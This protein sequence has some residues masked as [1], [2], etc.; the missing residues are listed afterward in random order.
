MK[1]PFNLKSLAFRHLFLTLLIV[2]FGL[3]MAYGIVR[4]RGDLIRLS[5]PAFITSWSHDGLE[6]VLIAKALLSGEGYIVDDFPLPP[7]KHIRYAGQE[8]LFKAPLYEFF[9]AG[10]FAISGFSFKLFFPLQA[11][12]GGLTSA[13]LGLIAWETFRRPATAL[14]AGLTAAA[15]PVLVNSASEPYNENLFLLL[16]VAAIWAFLVWF[17]TRTIKWALLCGV[18]VGLCTLTRESGIPLLVAM[19]AIGILSRPRGFRSWLACGTIALTAFAVIAP[20]TIRNYI[21][22]QA[23][24]PVAAIVG[25]D[26]ATGNNECVAPES[27]LTPYW[28]EGPCIPLNRRIANARAVTPLANLPAGILFDRLSRRAAL[29]FI[30]EHPAAYGPHSFLTFPEGTS[31][32]M[33]EL[34]LPFTG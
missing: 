10:V 16:F 23:F 22:F 25:E 30:T 27:F 29:D 20:W 7:G 19:A 17:R 12:F 3:R 5:G 34:P 28:A 9:L 2:G 31:V 14:L 33:T 11:L 13:L 18:M 21:R 32:C 26:L 6:H 8:A 1:E 24:V 4:Y 15:H